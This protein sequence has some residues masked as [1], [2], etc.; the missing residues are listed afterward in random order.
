MQISLGYVEVQFTMAFWF[1]IK[2]RCMHA[3]YC[4]S[5]RC[6]ELIEH[7]HKGRIQ[8]HFGLG[9]VCHV[10]TRSRTGPL[11]VQ[12]SMPPY[13]SMLGSNQHSKE[14]EREKEREVKGGKESERRK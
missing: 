10:S 13:G 12:F 5:P 11:V 6:F 9:K 2:C 14:G 8:N 3:F 7:C 1:L 4:S